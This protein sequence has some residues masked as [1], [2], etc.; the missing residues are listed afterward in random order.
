MTLS[1]STA[2][3]ELSGSFG[4]VASTHWL[5]SQVSMSVLERGGNA[6]D[7]AATGAFV[8]QVVEPHLNGIG[9]DVPIIGRAAGEA[10]PF[11]LCGQGP[12]PA[13][14]TL[15]AFDA[16]G[17]DAVPGSG[18][19]AACVPGAFGAWIALV[20][21]HGTIDVRT[22]LEPAIHYAENGFECLPKISATIAGVRDLFVDHWQSSAQVWLPDGTVP[23]PG[24]WLTNP[25]L[26]RTLR[27]IVE[28]AEA[29]SV[30]R[31]AQ[32]ERAHDAFYRGFVAEAVV[33]RLSTDAA[34]D[35]SGRRHQG[36]IDGDDLAGWTPTYESTVALDYR[37]TRV[38]KPG[39]WSQ[40]P[41]FLQQLALLAGWDLEELDPLSAELIH[42]VTECAKLAFAD[43]EAHYGD[44]DHVAVDLAGL[45][46][47]EYNQ[48][49][50]ALVGETA[51][52]GPMRPGSPGGRAGTLPQELASLGEGAA[53]IGEPTFGDVDDGRGDTCHID[54]VDRWGNVVT[55]TPSGGWLQSSPVVPEL[56]FALGTR[57]QM[58]WLQPGH[59]NVLAPGKRPRTTLST[60]FVEHE[61][62][63]LV[64]GTPGGD[65][66]DQCT[67]QFF[68]R[69]L[70]HGMG[71]QEAIEAPA[72][73]SEHFPSSFYPRTSHPGRLV[74]EDRFAPE[75]V[76][77][78]R[79][80]GHLVQQVD[81]WSVGRI[82]AVSRTAD[83]SRL[84]AGANPRG[85]QGYAVGR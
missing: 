29:G 45:L 63:V 28:E 69:H 8:L 57:A 15:D 1:G 54:V 17:L 62:G 5:A 6:F 24:S 43:R 12:A 79:A 72:S 83:G 13:G 10:E 49:R 70:H 82:S 16:L 58:F 81:P 38:H 48:A 7:A 50:R 61:D 4:M 32:L 27:R 41:V 76:A 44:P 66:Q 85:A 52:L 75:Q 84:R 77:D 64:F 73:Y 78:L 11:V 37:C 23:R 14:A 30:G 3:P 26:A 25:A 39:A 21:D 36:L 47:E 34:L 19:L 18:Y 71:L 33:E 40:G 55:A 20:R 68:L 80:R 35:S 53:G 59:P 60:T 2:R 31:E 65:T 51:D 74:L 56:G 67:V 46:D 9:G 42:L 22:L